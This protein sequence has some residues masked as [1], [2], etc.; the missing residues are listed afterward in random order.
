VYYN[1][2]VALDWISFLSYLILFSAQWDRTRKNNR[3]CYSCDGAR[4]L[5]V[6]R[7]MGDMEHSGGVAGRGT[8]KHLQNTLPSAT[9]PCLTDPTH[10]AQGLNPGM[11]GEGLV[12]ITAWA[13]TRSSLMLYWEGTGVEYLGFFQSICKWM[14]VLVVSRRDLRIYH[15]TYASRLSEGFVSQMQLYCYALV[16][17]LPLKSLRITK[18]MLVKGWMC[19][20]VCGNCCVW[21]PHCPSLWWQV[22][23]YGALV[24]W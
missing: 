12:T 8:A 14:E 2:S 7:L 24:G 16:H 21:S 23:D 19:V 20:C 1:L 5:F 4:L 17:T 3:W 9:S 15:L 11:S 6:L 10:T 22:D 13:V 18:T